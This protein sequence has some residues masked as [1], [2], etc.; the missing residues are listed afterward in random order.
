MSARRRAAIVEV[1]ASGPGRTARTAL[2]R[3]RTAPRSE[4]GRHHLFPLDW[5][6]RQPRGDTARARRRCPGADPT[7]A[8][9]TGAVPSST[10]VPGGD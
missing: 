2:A 7:L 10:I 3:P 8:H 5:T 1:A 4:P 6:T 9:G